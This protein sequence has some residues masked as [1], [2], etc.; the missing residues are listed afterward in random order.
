MV[1]R[2]DEQRP[3]EALEVTRGRLVLA[4]RAAVGQ[5][6]ARDHELRLDPLDQL[7]DPGA[8]RLVVERPSRAE[9]QVRHVKDAR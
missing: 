4:R 2:D 1:A 6:A 5:V 3:P 8:D 9:M 7:A